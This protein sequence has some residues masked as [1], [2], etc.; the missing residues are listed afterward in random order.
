M[1]VVITS[2]WHVGG[3]G[4]A[5]IYISIDFKISWYKKNGSFLEII[6]GLLE[7]QLIYYDG[8]C[9]KFKQ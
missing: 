2:G 6:N 7:K 3:Q 1:Q 5:Y 8:F 4:Y 9:S